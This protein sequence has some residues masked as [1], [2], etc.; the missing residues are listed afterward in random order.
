MKFIIK[1]IEVV[2]NL[3]YGIIKIFTRPKNKVVLI[4]RQS[5]E[6][7]LDFILIENKFIE[8][9]IN[10]QVKTLC[11]TLKKSPG[12]A[13]SYSFHIVRQM[14]HMATSR[15]VVLDSY[16][17]AASMLKHRNSLKIIQMWH[18]MGTMKKFGYQILDMEEGSNKNLALSMKMHHNYDYIFASSHAYSKYLAE[19]FGVS[20]DKIIIMPLPRLD[21]LCSDEYRNIKRDEICLS[22]AGL[23]GK[24]NILYCPTFRK[25]EKTFQKAI[26]G[27][28]ESVDFDKYNLIIKLHPLSKIEI[29]NNK[30]IVPDEYTT[31]DM[32]FASD[33]VIS[34]YSCIVYEAAALKIPLYFYTFDMDDY[35]VVR[36][37][38]FDYENEVPGIISQK[39]KEI[40]HEI[41]SNEY[42]MKGL[43]IFCRKYIVPTYNVTDKIV[44]FITSR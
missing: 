43:E 5:N 4:S 24:K 13:L 18:S 37:L 17:I 25:D 31:F 33:Y 38:T 11:K 22:Y 7:P 12:G 20:Q 1:V 27:L 21:L 32:L 30:V 40:I 6:T 36:G 15:V 41:N 10:W 8:K 34:D 28:I 44:D 35:S 39:P 3:I 26:D 16:C 14:Y 9:K 42:D 23:K 2:L 19:G 29:S